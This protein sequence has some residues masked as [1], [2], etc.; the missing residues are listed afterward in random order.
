[1]SFEKEVTE[2]I[3]SLC[4]D[5]FLPLAP[6]SSAPGP[7]SHPFNRTIFPV[8]RLHPG[9]SRTQAGAPLARGPKPPGSVSLPTQVGAPANS[10]LGTETNCKDT[11]F[12]HLNQWLFSM[13]LLQ[14]SLP[15]SPTPTAG[16]PILL[17]T[18]TPKHMRTNPLL[19]FT[20]NSGSDNTRFLCKHS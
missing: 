7:V 18:T 5:S 12:P 20:L 8:P 19:L 9:V 17:R 3:F 11:A 16:L 15:H 14:A 6:T 1:M 4:A 10:F 2:Q 13:L